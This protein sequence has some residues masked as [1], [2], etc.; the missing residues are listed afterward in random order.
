MI[1]ASA[2]ERVEACPASEALPKVT[3]ASE[4]ADRGSRLHRFIA[5]RLANRPIEEAIEHVEEDERETARGIVLSSLVGD[6]ETVT[7]ETAY[8]IDVHERTARFLGRNIDR[9][10][11][12]AALALGAPLTPFEICGTIDIEGRSR[13]GVE[14]AGDCKTGHK[15]QLPAVDHRQLHFEALARYMVADAPTVNGKIFQILQGGDVKVDAHLFEPLEL[16]TILDELGDIHS[17]VGKAREAFQLREDVRVSPGP[18]CSHCNALPLCPAQTA[19]ARAVTVDAGQTVALLSTMTRDQEWTA[20]EQ[21]KAGKKVLEAINAIMKTRAGQRFMM[22]DPITSPDGSK[23]F[24][25]ITMNRSDFSRPLALALL[26]ELGATQ[27]QINSLWV[28][29]Q[30][31]QFRIL[32]VKKSKVPRLTAKKKKAAELEPAK[33]DEIYDT[34]AARHNETNEERGASPTDRMR[35]RANER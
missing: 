34:A 31:E 5:A 11:E 6:L 8:A 30:D 26:S 4:W 10:Y 32:N 22:G 24:G 13:M 12:A 20:I 29:H 27:E 19:L 21:M 3:T 7:T 17:D 15:P 28:P 1:T 18:W 14:V 9:E 23:Y 2:L 35:D 25:P 16:D 33:V